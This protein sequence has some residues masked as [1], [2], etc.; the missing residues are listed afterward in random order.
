MMRASNSVYLSVDI[1]TAGPVPSDYALLAI[2]AC[3]MDQPDVSFYVELHPDRENIQQSAV[4]ISGL[5]PERLKL[6][7]TPPPEAMQAF[8]T[9]VLEQIP[10]GG[11]AIF[12]AF[13][14]P[15]DWMFVADYFHRYLGRNPFGHRALDIKAL[16][17]GKF[18]VPWDRTGMD[19]ITHELGLSIQLSHNA[20]EDARDQACIFNTLLPSR[21]DPSMDE[22]IK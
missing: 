14:A 9:W 15:F 12:V 16:F 5:E 6:E 17:M 22:E 11:Q 10:K 18:G 21:T 8:E 13:N 3:R 4:E 2:G 19:A 7:G 20:L 1:E